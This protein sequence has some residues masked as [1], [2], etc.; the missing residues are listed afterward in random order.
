MEL[1]H[2]PVL[3]TTALVHFLSSSA[4]FLPLF[5]F[6]PSPFPFCP[7]PALSP[8]TAIK[9]N[10]SFIRSN[11]SRGYIVLWWEGT[12][13]AW[14]LGFRLLPCCKVIVIMSW[15]TVVDCAFEVQMSF[16]S[17]LKSPY[18]H[19]LLMRSYKK[20]S[21]PTPNIRLCLWISIYL[22]TQ[23]GWNEF[24]SPNFLSDYFVEIEY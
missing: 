2:Q 1:W 13:L 23:M 17:I 20:K 7:F 4:S 19:H 14:T 18:Q 6:V 8:D 15:L 16:P 12:W 5:H 21:Y 3:Y 10:N 9:E 11:G 22:W 24:D